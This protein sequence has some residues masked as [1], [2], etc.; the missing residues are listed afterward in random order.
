VRLYATFF[1]QLTGLVTALEARFALDTQP[2]GNAPTAL[3]T[4]AKPVSFVNELSDWSGSWFGVQ[5]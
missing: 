4:H 5:N 3:G 2:I 1:F